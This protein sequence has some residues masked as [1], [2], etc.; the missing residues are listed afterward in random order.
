MRRDS[1]ASGCST[2]SSS[3]TPTTARRRSSRRLGV[4]GRGDRGDQRVEAALLLAGVERGERGGAARGRPRAAAARRG[5]RRRTSR[6][7]RARIAS[8]SSR[9]PRSARMRA[10]ATP[11]SARRGSSS[12]ARRRSSSLPASTSASA[13]EGSSSSRKRATT[14]GGCAPVNSDATAPS[15]NALTAGMPWIRKAAARRWLASVSTL[16]SATLPA[17]L[18]DRLLEHRRELAARPA[19]LGPEVDDDRQLLR[20]L[21]DVLLEGGLGGVEDHAL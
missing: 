5:P 13:S 4:V 12:S 11:A 20:A 3:S 9:S 6:G 19:P 7:T 2:P 10:S 15:L 21:D 1:R 8:A 16:A 14:A 17:A 18:V